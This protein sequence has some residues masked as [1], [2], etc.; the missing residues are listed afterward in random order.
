MATAFHGPSAARSSTTGRTG[1]RRSPARRGAAAE[2][3]MHGG[4][5]RTFSDVGLSGSECSGSGCLCLQGNGRERQVVRPGRE[6]DHGKKEYLVEYDDGD[7]DWYDFKKIKYTILPPKGQAGGDGAGADTSEQPRRRAT[8]NRVTF[9]SLG[10]HGVM[11]LGRR[12]EIFW[13]NPDA[14]DTWYSGTIV[15]FRVSDSCHFVQFDDGDSDWYN[16]DEIK[17]RV[18]TSEVDKVKAQQAGA[19]E[20][21]TAGAVKDD[22]APPPNPSS[23][24]PHRALPPHGARAHRNLRSE[25]GRQEETPRHAAGSGFVGGKIRGLRSGNFLGGR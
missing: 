4:I 25:S 5:R 16:L 8:K 18:P 20:S 21:S 9:A 13:S 1:T 10:M 19:E 24:A 23:P 22:N 3:L 15:E 6:F 17:Y 11:L 7:R 12:V 2:K 14:A